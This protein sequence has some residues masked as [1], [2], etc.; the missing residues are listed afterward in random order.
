MSALARL[1]IKDNSEKRAVTAVWIREHENELLLEEVLTNNLEL[2]GLRVWEKAEKLFRFIANMTSI[3][4]ALNYSS[5]AFQNAE[6][7]FEQVVRPG[8]SESEG[9][10]LE[11]EDIARFE[12][13]HNLMGISCA[14]NF[15]ELH[16][17]LID[18]LVNE[19]HYLIWDEESSSLRVSA[20]GWAHIE[21]GEGLPD[22]HS[23]F[24]AMW[25]DDKVADLWDKGIRSGIIKA[26]YHPD[27]IDKKE[28]S[29]KIDDEILAAIRKAKFVV[30]DFT[31]QRGGVYFEAG[32]ALG[33]GQK[34]IW[35][36]E[37]SEL[38]G[39]HFDTRQYNFILWEFGKYDELARSLSIRIEAIFGKGNYAEPAT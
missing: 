25:F 16:F 30:A 18:Y 1:G 14:K 19:K 39:V 23:A 11:D 7:T 4:D 2:R 9:F 34:V 28:H 22:S 12:P 20:S 32:F 26:G 10:C 13:L 24:V 5:I 36:C 33:L 31:G 17:L 38:V 27:R 3:G 15:F 37:K 29:N 8:L 21:S 35:L 6:L